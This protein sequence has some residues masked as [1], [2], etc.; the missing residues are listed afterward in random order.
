MVDSL[1]RTPLIYYGGKTLLAELVVANLPPHYGFVDVFGGGA[2][3]LLAKGKSPL[4]VYNDIGWVSNFFKVLRDQ[5]EELYR[6]LSLTPWSRSEFYDSL[7]WKDEQDEIE[8]ARKWFVLVSQ[9]FTHQESCKSWLVQSTNTAS[10]F[11]NRVDL[12]PRVVDRLRKVVIENRS[13]EK[14][15]PL[16]DADNMLFYCDPPYVA[17][18]RQNGGYEHE[19]SDTKH[20]ELLYNLVNNVKGQVVISGYHSELY[21]S[22]LKSWRLVEKER[23]SMIHNSK[24]GKEVERTRTECIWVKERKIA[25][26]GF[27]E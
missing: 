1:N 24:A 4:E 21:D 16:Y 15:I 23:V 7:N 12:I 14:L 26:P 5:G 9:G 25:L 22:Y 27:N 3:V 20:E 2:G 18:T 11:S 6:R 13:F 8:K 10:A 19:M 17:S